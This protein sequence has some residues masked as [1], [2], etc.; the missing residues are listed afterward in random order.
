MTSQRIGRGMRLRACNCRGIRQEWAL[1]FAE[2]N[3]P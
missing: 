1:L 3:P 2:E